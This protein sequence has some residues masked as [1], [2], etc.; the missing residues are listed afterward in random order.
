MHLLHEE[1]A[2]HV[3]PGLGT[4]VLDGILAITRSA[5]EKNQVTGAGV[6]QQTQT[7]LLNLH[8][9]QSVSGIH[10]IRNRSQPGVNW[11]EDDL[12]GVIVDGKRALAKEV[13]AD[14]GVYPGS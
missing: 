14:H 10:L 13:K 11:A 7:S 4:H 12:L 9:D 3:G 1:L 2:P 5:S 6:H 8:L